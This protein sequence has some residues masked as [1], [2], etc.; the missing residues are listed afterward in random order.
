MNE[1]NLIPNSERSP[2]ELREMTRR[3]GIASGQTR[4][5]K[6]AVKQVILDVLYAE[7]PHGGTVLEEMISGMIERVSKTGDQN[8]FEKLMEY[9]DM[10]PDRKRKDT[11]LKLKKEQTERMYPENPEYEDTSEIDR[12]ILSYTGPE[13]GDQDADD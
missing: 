8:T 3:G 10:S 4:R 9:A 12:N 7:S 13:N 2:S 11:E 5:R 6:K 1:Q